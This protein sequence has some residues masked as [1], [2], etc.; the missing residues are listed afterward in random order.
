M[1]KDVKARSLELRHV[2][3]LDL[4]SLSTNTNKVLSVLKLP[5]SEEVLWKAFDSKLRNQIRKAMKSGI[6]VRWGHEDVLPDFYSV[7]L[8]NMRDLGTPALGIEFFK[9]IVRIHGEAADV[10]VLYQGD[11]PIAVLLH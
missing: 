4:R 10:L 11:T 3:P 8:R 5:D 2:L 9:H 1:A 6:T 7:F